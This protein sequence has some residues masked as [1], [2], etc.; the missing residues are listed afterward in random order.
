MARIFRYGQTRDSFV[1][2]LLYTGTIEEQI[3]RNNLVKESLFSNVR[4]PN[5]LFVGRQSEGPRKGGMFAVAGRRQAAQCR[6]GAR[7]GSPCGS[8]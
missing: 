5:P 7:N 4:A 6:V 2:R 3:Y 8:V 1:Y